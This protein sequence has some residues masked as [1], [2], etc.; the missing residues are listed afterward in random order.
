[1]VTIRFTSLCPETTQRSVPE[2]AWFPALAY[3][4]VQLLFISYNI[5]YV[6]ENMGLFYRLLVICFEKVESILYF[7]NISFSSLVFRKNITF[8]IIAK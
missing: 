4:V 7:D 5:L 8:M 1:M 3:H 6:K 2:V